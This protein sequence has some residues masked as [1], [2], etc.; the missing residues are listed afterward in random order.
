[1]ARERLR[2]TVVEQEEELQRATTVMTSAL[3]PGAEQRRL[4]VA[5]AFLA[6]CSDKGPG[7]TR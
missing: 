3:P 4:E 2:K 7:M 5:R 1:M 6:K